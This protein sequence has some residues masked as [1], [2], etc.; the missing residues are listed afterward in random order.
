MLSC[1]A[2]LTAGNDH[3]VEEISGN[4][5]RPSELW[6]LSSAKRTG[7]CSSVRHLARELIDLGQVVSGE[8]NTNFGAWNRTSLIFGTRREGVRRSA[9]YCLQ[10][11]R[12]I[13]FSARQP[14]QGKRSISPEK[15]TKT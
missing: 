4:V 14:D 10:V 1:P 15:K 3:V 9:I 5:S 2:R 7:F 11:H 12:T 8:V 13:V 6:P